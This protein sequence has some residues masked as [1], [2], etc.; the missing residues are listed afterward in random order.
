MPLFLGHFMYYLCLFE[1]TLNN[2]VSIRYISKG[3][4]DNISL[5]PPIRRLHIQKNIN[6]A[7]YRGIQLDHMSMQFILLL[8]TLIV[9]VQ[10]K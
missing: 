9:Y 6:N 5:F 3:N 2:L 8:L 4:N 7:K 1:V 10:A